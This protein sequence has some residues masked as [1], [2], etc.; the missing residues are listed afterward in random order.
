MPTD[1]FVH[2]K[3]IVDEWVDEQLPSSYP[4]CPLSEY[5]DGKII[6]EPIHGYQVL[7][8]HEY[9]ILDTPIVQRL[10]YIHQTSLAYLVYPGA[11]H[12]R[13]D[14]SLGVAYVAEQIGH[15][16][17]CDPGRIGELRLA[18]LLHDIGH[19]LFSH[20]SESLMTQHFSRIF[21]GARRSEGLSGDLSL[22][23]ILSYLIITSPRFLDLI[24]KITGHFAPNIDVDNIAKLVIGN[25]APEFAYLGDIIHGP[26]DADKLDYLV[27]DCYFSGIRAD[28]D[29]PRLVVSSIVLNRE[30]FSV[31]DYPLRNLVMKRVG[32][33]NL[34]QVTFNKM[35]LFPAIYHHH[36]IRAIECMVRGIFESIWDN[37][38][39]VEKYP[40]LR[41][42]SIKDFLNVSE[43]E[44]F[45]L[46]IQEPF[47]Q[48]KIS[49]LLR[50]ELLERCL[51][52]SMDYIINPGA[53]K[54]DLFKV[55]TEDHPEQIRRL[56][57]LM[58]SYLPKKRQSDFHD[59][60]ID[61]PK[62]PSVGKDA[63]EC[64]I[65]S[66]TS[67]LSYLRDYFPYP[68]WVESYQE[69]KWKGY[70]FYN[71]DLESRQAACKVAK[72]VLRE[73]YKV[74]KLDSN[75][76]NEAKIESK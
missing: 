56:R 2:L 40:K 9:I 58:W 67:S 49:R 52:I 47:L 71:S 33:S 38:D 1:E 74:I 13:F 5:K 31:A 75:S 63:D 54:D 8:P 69:R 14:H 27:R 10:R 16:L 39:K 24:R 41:F 15:K 20:L 23:E 30:R 64:L 7:Q 34:E 65:D 28:I 48:P 12:T 59:L 36:K 6:R 61:L 70:I 17:G 50:R 19:C 73:R 72:R 60:W 43:Y 35:L 44:F 18:A 57:E 22:G 53:L 3:S 37:P 21:L 68:R 11:N 62:R 66:G 76:T 42:S 29:I 46:G 25:T 32:V 26:F 55:S 45:S 51:V 4:S